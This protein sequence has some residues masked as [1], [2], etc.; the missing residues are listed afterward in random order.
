MLSSWVKLIRF[1]CVITIC[2]GSSLIVEAKEKIE[3]LQTE[4][5]RLPPFHAIKVEIPCIIDCVVGK[6]GDIEIQ[7][8]DSLPYPYIVTSVSDGTLRLSI[9]R[10]NIDLHK[11]NKGSVKVAMASSVGKGNIWYFNRPRFRIRT[12]KL[13]GFEGMCVSASISGLSG[14]SFQMNTTGKSTVKLS[15]SVTTLSANL[16]RTSL[17]AGELSVQVAKIYMNCSNYAE[18]NVLKKLDVRVTGRGTI[19]YRGNP[20][21]IY[22]PTGDGVIKKI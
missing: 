13:D 16:W 2:C 18:V 5:R 15:G 12:E 21:V 6:D 14:S 8:D 4:N 19:R 7:S 3:K 1:C 10:N 11:N 9:N 20:K 22:D 17:N